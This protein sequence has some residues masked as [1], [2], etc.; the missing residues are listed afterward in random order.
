MFH[1]FE[2]ISIDLS[3]EMKTVNTVVEKWPTQL[4]LQLG[5]KGAEEE[6]RLKLGSGFTNIERYVEWRRVDRECPECCI[7]LPA[8]N[9]AIAS[10]LEHTRLDLTQPSF[11]K[12]ANCG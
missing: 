12:C 11:T 1:D 9:S 8:V 7:P 3:V 2:Q 5:Q 4:K 6:F 10:I